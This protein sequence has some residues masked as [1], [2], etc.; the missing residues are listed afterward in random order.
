MWHGYV[1]FAYLGA[2][3][4]FATVGLCVRGGR[5]SSLPTY[6]VEPT[7][8]DKDGMRALFNRF[9]RSE[10][11]KELTKDGFADALLWLGVPIDRARID[12]LWYL[13]DP[14]NV[15]TVD[16]DGFRIGMKQMATLSNQ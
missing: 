13:M 4:G 8:E 6:T 7:D 14:E 3:A 15:G 2:V 10:S 11:T 1:R 9:V 16:L 12:D 5:R